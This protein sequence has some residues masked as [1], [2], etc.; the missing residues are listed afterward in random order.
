M[1]ERAA[2]GPWGWLRSLYRT[3][4]VLIHEMVKF[5]LVGV[6]G[7]VIDVGLFNAFRHF[8]I[9]PLTSKAMSTTT[10]AVVSYFLNRH[11]SF[12]HLA[13]TGTGRELTLFLV[14]SAVGLGIAEVCLATSH[15]LLGLHSALADNV[16]ANGFGLVLGTAWRFWSFKRWV[17]LP[18][19]PAPDAGREAALNAPV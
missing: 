15:Y 18:L 5:G 7:V 1:G 10:A 12:S 11:W 4:G 19:E 2:A 8:G 13:R 16:S 17:F 14:L 6:L 3:F 9:G